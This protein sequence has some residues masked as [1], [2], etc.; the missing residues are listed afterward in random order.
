MLTATNVAGSL[1]LVGMRRSGMQRADIDTVRWVFDVIQKRKLS[2]PNL[3]L[4][5]AQRQGDPIVDEYVRFIEAA[6]RPITPNTGS[7]L[8]GASK[9]AVSE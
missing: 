1:N 5:L 9:A 6:K 7:V 8:R 2:R 4:T 3:L